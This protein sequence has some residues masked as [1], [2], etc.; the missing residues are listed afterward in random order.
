MEEMVMGDKLEELREMF[1]ICKVPDTEQD[2]ALLF[3]S[4][5]DFYSRLV[6]FEN[7]EY[8]ILIGALNLLKF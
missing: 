3:S 4:I 7:D 2:I 8:K 6:Q 5:A 1:N